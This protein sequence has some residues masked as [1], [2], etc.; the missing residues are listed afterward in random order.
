MYVQ[1]YWWLLILFVQPLFSA[2]SVKSVIKAPV[3]VTGFSFKQ[4][5]IQ[6]NYREIT[7]LGQFYKNVSSLLRKFKVNHYYGFIS[8]MEYILRGQ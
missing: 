4:L 8:F 7:D 3:G 1:L 2:W 6:N 5:C